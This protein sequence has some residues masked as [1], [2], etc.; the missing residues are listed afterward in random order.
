[1]TSHELAHF[2]LEQP[3]APIATADDCGYH[4]AGTCYPLYLLK[5]PVQGESGGDFDVPL[6]KT[7]K[8]KS[9]LMIVVS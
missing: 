4:E 8:N 5:K 2:L 1:M 6:T 9:V 7:D 3:D